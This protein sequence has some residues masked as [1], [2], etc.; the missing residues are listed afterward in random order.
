MIILDTNVVSE[1]MRPRP[2]QAVVRWVSAQPAISL[3]T[4]TITEAEILHG[5]LLLPRGKR[6]DALATAAEEM[7]TEDFAGRI[8]SF[9]SEAARAYARIAVARRRAG[10]PVS[11][12][13][14]QIAA[15]AASTGARLATRNVRDF[16]ES[17][18]DVIDPWA[19]AAT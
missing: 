19:H 13:D 9:G 8:L 11:G 6:R 12:F 2:L 4:T 17:N 5:V 10:L 15:I 14:T 7:F 18:L 16:E 3:Y 1:L